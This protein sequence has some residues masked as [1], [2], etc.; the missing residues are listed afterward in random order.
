MRDTEN[1]FLS[2][3][4]ILLMTTDELLAKETRR[5]IANWVV[6]AFVAGTAFG[7]LVA[8]FGV[9]CAR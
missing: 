3:R 2:R 1:E 8:L 6:G 9:W 7:A 4:H 5:H